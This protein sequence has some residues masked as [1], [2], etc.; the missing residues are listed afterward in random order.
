MTFGKINLKENIWLDKLIN[1]FKKFAN[2]AE[3]AIRGV[4]TWLVV[5]ERVRCKIYRHLNKRHFSGM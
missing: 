5:G 4:V 3:I 1:R 2:G